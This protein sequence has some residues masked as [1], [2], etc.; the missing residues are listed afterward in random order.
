[1]MSMGALVSAQ[2][3]TL[4]PFSYKDK[5]KMAT[6]GRASAVAQIRSLPDL[7][8]FAA[9]V[10]WV[11]LHVMSLL[12]NRNRFA[13]MVNLGAKY[14]FWGSHNAIVGESPDVVARVAKTLDSQHFPSKRDAKKESKQP[15]G[16]LREPR[17]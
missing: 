8:G 6:V 15:T 17:P 7:K 16:N 12:G 14:L 13:T 11:V 3:K 10:I 4:K 2:N 1:M 9:W 5:G